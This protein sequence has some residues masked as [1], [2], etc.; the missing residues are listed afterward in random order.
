MVSYFGLKFSV[1]PLTIITRH[2]IKKIQKW[3]IL[4]RA[5]EWLPF[6]APDGNR[7]FVYSVMT[8][9]GHS[10]RNVVRVSACSIFTQHSQ[11]NKCS[12]ANAIISW[13]STLSALK[14]I[15]RYRRALLFTIAIVVIKFSKNQS[16]PLKLCLN[17]I[18]I[19]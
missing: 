11:P 17:I 16:L 7:V 12:S 15:H 14:S 9:G 19:V 13:K 8:N 2:Q 10:A 3:G 5:W 4:K 1:C 6:I 18:I